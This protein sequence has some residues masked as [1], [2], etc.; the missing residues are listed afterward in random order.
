MRFNHYFKGFVYIK[1]TG[2]RPEKLINLCLDQGFELWSATKRFDGVYVYISLQDFFAIRPLVKRSE[3]RISVVAYQGFPFFFKKVKRRKMFVLGLFLFCALLQYASNFIFFVHI[4]GCEQ[5]PAVV[6]RQALAEGGIVPGAKKD[7]VNKKQAET[8]L[9]LAVPELAWA[10]IQF[11]GTRAVVEVAEKNM[12]QEESREPADYVAQKDGVICEWI[13]LNG[14]GQKKQGDTVRAGDIL[15]KGLLSGKAVRATGI[16]KAKIHY[17]A[18]GEESLSTTWLERTGQQR[19]SYKIFWGGRELTIKSAPNPPFTSFE[20]EVFCKKV[21]LWR[22]PDLPVEFT[23]EDFYETVPVYQEKTHEEATDSAVRH[24]LAV[25]SEQ[26][27]ETAQIIAKNTE[28]VATDDP[29]R[30]KVKVLVETIEEIGENRTS[31]QG[32]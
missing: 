2:K 7:E 25:L 12:P 4:T 18:T 20:R 21:L 13:V 1:V 22:N 32:G 11:M 9:L 5:V 29:N 8:A 26:I 10:S 23:R 17:E 31:L 28:L 16:V 3:T 24:A 27:P 19:D 6:V 15:I 14:Q 30:V